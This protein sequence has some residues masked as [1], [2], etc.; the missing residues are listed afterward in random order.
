MKKVYLITLMFYLLLWSTFSNAQTLNLGI[1]SSF[2]AYTATGA[3]TNSGTLVTGDVGSNNGIISGFAAPSYIDNVYNANAVTDQC[4][5]DL[6]R[7]YIHVN[8]L[9]VTYP[10]SHAPAFGGGETITSG[11]YSTNGAGSVG[12]ALTLDGEGDPNAYFVIKCN[13]ALTIG[14]GATV[15]LINGAK[16][17]NV[18][19]IAE[20]AVTVAAGAEV[21]GTLFAHLGAVS[22]GVNVNLEGRMFSLEGAITIGAGATAI[23]PPCNS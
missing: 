20:G 10:G 8:D 21:K 19:W 14:A 6:L 7:L 15:T 4:R 11:V 13:G 18:F 12:G 16:S 23:K 9:F 22:L 17:C 1:L 3:V 2:E 5:F